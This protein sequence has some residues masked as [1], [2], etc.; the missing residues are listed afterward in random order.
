MQILSQYS[1]WSGRILVEHVPNKYLEC[2]PT[3]WGVFNNILYA[4]HDS[5]ISQQQ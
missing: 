3:N 1:R 2:T 4:E 5:D